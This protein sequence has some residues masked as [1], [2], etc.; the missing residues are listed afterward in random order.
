MAENGYDIVAVSDV[1]L[2]YGSPQVVYFMRSLAEHYERQALI[3]EPD[4]PQ[5]KPYQPAYPEIEIERLPSVTHP[6]S[7]AGRIDY[8]SRA[9]ERI[10]QLK[11]RVLVLFCTYSLPVMLRLTCKP[12]FVIYYS[13]ES[14][15][16][17]GRNDVKLNRM[18]ADRLDLIIF[19][20]E[21][22]AR[23]DTRRCGFGRQ[24]IAILYNASS[25]P[26]LEPLEPQWRNGR[27]LY[28]GTLDAERTMAGFLTTPESSAFPLDIYGHIRGSG[29]EL[30][31]RDLKALSDNARFLGYVDS[32]T[33]SVVR[34][35]A[36]FALTLWAPLNENQRFASPNK[37]FEAIADGVPPI[38]TPHPQ[39][40]MLIERYECGIL[41]T[42]WDYPAYLQ[43]L[44]A[45]MALYGTPAYRR[46][47]E[48]CRNAT[49]QELNWGS[50]F[51]KVRR[52][53][54]NL[55]S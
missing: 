25:L 33:L 37:F 7:T 49:V 9:A 36:A 20:E 50:Q 40:R 8:T 28:A 32:L 21:Q 23:L 3:I 17:Y 53:L 16:A 29:H 54:P 18:L 47:V 38:T 27:I 48:N 22:R 13:I 15:L 6:H 11:P 19:P 45:V 39:M 14:I 42:G 10:N 46:M 52:L 31:E 51:E 12:E 24:P 35:A 44:E 55:S 43:A 30:L 26:Q 4:E 2:G 5:K 41:M 1:S 34:Q